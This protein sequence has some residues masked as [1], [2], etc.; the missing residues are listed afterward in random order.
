MASPFPH[1]C[2]VGLY[3]PS[4][5]L[6]CPFPSRAAGDLF[7]TL[8]RLALLLWEPPPFHLSLR[9]FPL[10]V[11]SPTFLHKYFTGRSAG[12]RCALSLKVGPFLPVPDFPST[13]GSIRLFWKW[14]GRWFLSLARPSS[15]F[16]FPLA[17]LPLFSLF[18]QP[19]EP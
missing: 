10:R 1:H 18:S 19:L 11:V 8:R 9:A 12:Y 17:V 16:F 7:I 4:S 15:L 5:P 2:L 3:G 13:L 14:R 6:Q